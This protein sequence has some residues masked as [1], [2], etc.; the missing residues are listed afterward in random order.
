[1]VFFFLLCLFPCFVES[2]G[3]R[4]SADDGGHGAAVEVGGARCVAFEMSCEA[5]VHVNLAEEQQA[6]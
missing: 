4:R 1:M 6:S 2:L 3:Q 5:R